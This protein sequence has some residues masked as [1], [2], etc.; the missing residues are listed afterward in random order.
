MGKQVPW[1]II[2]EIIGRFPKGAS[3]EE[4][5][6]GLDLA[7]SRRTLQRC[8]SLLVKRNEIVAVG[9]ARAR[10]YKLFHSP[11]EEKYETLKSFSIH[12]SEVGALIQEKV[13]QPLHVRQPVTYNRAFLEEYRPNSTYYLAA[14][15]RKKMLEMGGS[16]DGR[17]PA[18]TYARQI[19]ERLLIDLSWNS[20]RLEGNTYSLIETQRLLDQGKAAVGK[21]LKETQMILNHKAAIEFLIESAKEVA[22]NRFTILNLHTFLS[23]NLMSDP[24]ACGRLRTI[25]VGISHSTYIPIAIPQIIEEC[26]DLLLSKAQKIKDPFEQSFFLMVHIPYLQAFDDVNKRTSRLAA[27]IPL[28]RKN[29]CPLSFVDVPEKMYINGLLG[30][31][32]LNKIDL[33]R[34]VFIWAYERSCMRYATTR[35]AMG[36]PDPFLLQYRNAI[37]QA[38]GEVVRGCL[39]KEQAV[40]SIRQKADQFIPEQDRSRF[41]EAVE[42]ELLA[43]HEGN[44]ARYKLREGEYEKW[45]KNWH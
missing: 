12:I 10:R 38:V 42:R 35:K 45:Q 23:D 2:L 1:D 29:L 15:V 32:E 43:L 34:D 28:I 33:L 44:V 24:A 20:S 31:Y 25:A 39:N 9:R 36:E 30:I 26:F 40:S 16:E 7:F 4:I 8:L 14:D 13:L 6:L 19:F 11:E 3:L 5:L 22:I 17:Y 37:K 41:I 27:N 18:G 21:D